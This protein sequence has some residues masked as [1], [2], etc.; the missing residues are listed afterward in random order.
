MIN[1][2]YV[3]DNKYRIA[4]LLVVMVFGLIVLGLQT[5]LMNRYPETAII[6]DYEVTDNGY[7]VE[8]TMSNG[9]MFLYE[10]DDGDFEIG[11]CFSLLMD[12]NDTAEVQ[13]DKIVKIKYENFVNLDNLCLE[14]MEKGY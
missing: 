2:K 7:L 9:N 11:D 6:T 14:A 4:N 10:T 12:N 3:E 13:D 1:R 5:K 8:F